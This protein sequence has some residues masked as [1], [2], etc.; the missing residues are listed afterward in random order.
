MERRDVI[1]VLSKT[2]LFGR[3]D[4]VTLGGLADVSIS[5]VYPPGQYL[6]FQGDPGDYLAVIVSGLVK[7]VVTSEQGDEMV[8][9]TLGPP[10]TV[11][12]L[13]V[14]D[15]GPRSA[16]VIAAGTTTVL[17]IS[18]PAI[19][20]LVRTSPLLLDNL[21]VSL[22]SLVRRLTEQASDLVF[23]DV[24]GRVAKLLVR[25]ADERGREHGG[26]VTL[27]LGVTQSDLARMVGASRPPVNRV[28]QALAARG[29]ITMHGRT[30]VIRDAAALR[31][32][33]GL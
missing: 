1:S 4:D 5:R 6:W 28:L 23:L 20:Q 2:T 33:A 10:E 7:V 24:A 15:Q 29:L 26:S 25:L 21:L 32:R 11:G 31:R 14:I 3:L 27:D 19:L 30:I 16:S 17:I 12:E 22:G 8:L 13:A 18:R 9:V